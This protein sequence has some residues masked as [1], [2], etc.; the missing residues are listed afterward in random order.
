MKKIL[1][2]ILLTIG[3]YGCDD[4]LDELNTDK[5][6]PAAVDPSSLFTRGL[7]ETFNNMVTPNVNYMDSIGLKLLILRNLSIT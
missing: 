3:F 4:R 6:N 1:F 7:V 2:L 5:I